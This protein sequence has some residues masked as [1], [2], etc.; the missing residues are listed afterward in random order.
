MVLLT[1]QDTQHTRFNDNSS[2][3]NGSHGRAALV[4]LEQADILDITAALQKAASFDAGR[5]ATASASHLSS[6]RA[7]GAAVTDTDTG[8]DDAPFIVTGP[9]LPIRQARRGINPNRNYRIFGTPPFVAADIHPQQQQQHQHQHP[10]PIDAMFAPPTPVSASVSSASYSSRAGAERGSR[11]G[12]GSSGASN[13]SSASSASAGNSVSDT[14]STLEDILAE[15]GRQI[16]VY[17]K[18]Q[19]RGISELAMEPVVLPTHHSTHV[20]SHSSNART[21]YGHG[22]ESDGRSGSVRVSSLLPSARSSPMI[23]SRR[24]LSKSVSPRGSLAPAAGL[25][26][27]QYYVQRVPNGPLSEQE[28][29]S[30]ELAA[31]SA[32]QICIA[33]PKARLHEQKQQQLRA[34]TSGKQP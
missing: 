25:A 24:G 5:Q 6:R 22:S 13:K 7:S 11:L 27:Q 3:S 33:S 9:L 34:L 17:D 23:S 28:R 31:R 21:P 30:N 10:D 26:A 15:R 18:H 1:H 14:L 2:S 20:R 8:L 16:R 12:S 4:A 32:S 29:L 19:M